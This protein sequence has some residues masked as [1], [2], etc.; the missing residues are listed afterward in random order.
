MSPMLVKPSL[1][2]AMAPETVTPGAISYESTRPHP[3]APL[4]PIAL[5]LHTYFLTAEQCQ[6]PLQRPVLPLLSG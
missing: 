4:T 5:M 3:Q 1:Q 2:T 6:D